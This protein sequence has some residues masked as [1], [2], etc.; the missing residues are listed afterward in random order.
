MFIL[1]GCVP[2]NRA[3]LS[4]PLFLGQG[5]RYGLAAAA[6][7]LATT[8]GRQM[9]LLG[10]A[11]WARLA[12]IATTCLLPFNMCL[13]A[14]LR[15]ADPAIIATVL[16]C[17]P[18]V[19]AAAGPIMSRQRPSMRLVCAAAVVVAGTAMVQGFGHADLAGIAL[20]AG[21]LA[22]D[23]AFTVL[24]A[25]MVADLQPVVVATGS[26][27][28]AVPVFLAAGL[29][30]GEVSRWRA[31]TAAQAMVLLIFALALTSLAFCWWFAGLRRA[32]VARAGITISWVP[33]TAT[34]VSAIMD[35]AW[36]RLGQTAGVGVVLI[37][38]ALGLLN[39]RQRQRRPPP[40]AARPGV[41]RNT[42]A[43]QAHGTPK[44]PAS[45]ASS[46]RQA[47]QTRFT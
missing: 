31:P 26:C 28:A 44:V 13:L 7:C 30:S 5:L 45:T 8:A 9:R 47:Q 3:L 2:L 46:S 29:V 15:H 4:Y 32:G 42:L 22:A 33:V 35:H 40:I 37:G 12:T 1:G 24:A 34:L 25:Q 6:L 11:H 23:V 18:L 16:G 41:E 27:A 17:A 38:F 21:A 20:A 14:G 19:L 10:P 39:P 43:G 36:P